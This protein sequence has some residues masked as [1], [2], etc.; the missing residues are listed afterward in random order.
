MSKSELINQIIEK[1][2]FANKKREDPDFCLCLN[3]KKCHDLPD[4]E[5]ICVG[6]Y[7]P[8]YLLDSEHPQG[9]C[10]INS[11]FGKP[12]DREEKFGRPDLGI[13]LE[14]T[15]CVIPQTRTYAKKY[16]SRFS[17]EI[18]SRIYENNFKTAREL[19]EFLKE[20]VSQE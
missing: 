17:E 18:L 15:N 1:Y 19:C 5:L 4:T 12:L 11:P 10:R 13:I 14:C 6:C 20:N 3:G 16:L 2:S 8:E 7:C 9:K